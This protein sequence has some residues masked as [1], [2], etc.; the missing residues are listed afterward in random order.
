M[1]CCVVWS[2]SVFHQVSKRSWY[3]NPTTI[4]WQDTS[5]SKGQWWCYRNISTSRNF[6]GMSA[7]ISSPAL[8]TLLPNR[9]QRNS[10]CTPLCLLLTS[11]G[12]TSQWTTCQ[13]SHPPRGEMTVFL[14]LLIAF[15][16]W[17]FKPPARRT[18][19]QKPLPS[20]FLNEY[21]H[22]LG[23]HK[24]LSQTVIVGSSTHF[25]RASGD[26]GAPARHVRS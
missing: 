15:P 23:S 20:S 4:R 2:I 21:G 5:M 7:S 16:R 12:N 24:P 1:G 22:I 17:R 18:S 14:W 26:V 6:D 25:G 13:A 10:V 11:H 9:P 19:Q 8:P 3:G